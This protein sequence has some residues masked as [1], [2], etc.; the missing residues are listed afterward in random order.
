MQ[1]VISGFLDQEVL[2]QNKEDRNFKPLDLNEII[3]RSITSNVDYAARKEI[4]L[5]HELTPDLPQVAANEFRLSQILDNLIG[6]AMKFCSKGSTVEVRTKVENNKVFAEV[7]DNGPGLTEDDFAKLFTKHAKLSNQ[8]TGGEVSS[9]V[10]LALC[11][12]LINLD[13]GAIGARN[14]SDGG[15]TFWISLPVG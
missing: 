8:P 4:H 10:G 2:R 11:K 13:E 12:Q 14:N 1:G 3:L 15:A 9:G 7:T 5:N 6:N